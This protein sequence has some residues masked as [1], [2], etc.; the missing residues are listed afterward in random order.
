[1]AKNLMD[2]GKPTLIEPVKEILQF[3][4][5][6]RVLALVIWADLSIHVPKRVLEESLVD[7]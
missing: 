1:M 4:S 2:S 7:V 3:T 5:E 6:M